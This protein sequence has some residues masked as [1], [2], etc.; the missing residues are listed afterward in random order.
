MSR[1]RFSFVFVALALYACS[2]KPR[3]TEPL[4]SKE[5][6]M[7][8]IS[9]EETID[10]WKIITHSKMMVPRKEIIKHIEPSISKWCMKHVASQ[11]CS[12]QKLIGTIIAPVKGHLW[13]AMSDGLMREALKSEDGHIKATYWVAKPGIIKSLPSIISKGLGEISGDKEL[14][15]LKDKPDFWNWFVSGVP[16]SCVA[17]P[18]AEHQNRVS[19]GKA[20]GAEPSGAGAEVLDK[21][22][23]TIESQAD[24]IPSKEPSKIED[25]EGGSK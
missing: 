20:I 1:Y 5:P 9:A 8:R 25:A 23:E 13:L 14:D 10:G 17:A 22:E 16:G 6:V 24:A 12:D 18:E 2:S 21:G 15:L 7:E 4:P 19:G 11:T 3:V